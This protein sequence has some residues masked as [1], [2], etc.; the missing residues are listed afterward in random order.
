LQPINIRETAAEVKLRACRSEPAARS[1]L[2]CGSGEAQA[3]EGRPAALMK[4]R[5]IRPLDRL[6]VDHHLSSEDSCFLYKFRIL[7]AADYEYSS[8]VHRCPS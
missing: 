2:A 4:A 6:H 1:F 5:T 3:F 8:D 7:L